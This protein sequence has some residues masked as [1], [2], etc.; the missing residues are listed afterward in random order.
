MRRRFI[1]RDGEMVEVPLDYV[2]TTDAV[3]PMVMNDI[4]PYRSMIDGSIV[5]FA[6]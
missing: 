5:T 3:A 2:R 6:R 1:Y 4:K